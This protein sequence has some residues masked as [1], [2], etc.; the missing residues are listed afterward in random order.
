[1][2]SS[3]INTKKVEEIFSIWSSYCL[4]KK[5]NFGEVSIN[6]KKQNHAIVI[7]EKY[8][9]YKNNQ[10]PLNESVIIVNK[11][12]KKMKAFIFKRFV[13]RPLKKEDASYS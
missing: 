7:I 13:K 4:N 5:F 6:D 11:D 2:I 9:G 12:I 8:Y 10:I 3:P 1:M